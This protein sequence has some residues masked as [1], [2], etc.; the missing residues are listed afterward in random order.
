MS[1]LFKKS[2]MLL[3]FIFIIIQSAISANTDNPHGTIKWPC[4]ACHTTASWK[5]IKEALDFDHNETGFPLLGI[6]E[7]IKCR[8]CHANLT[9]AHIGIECADCHTDIH[10][11]QFGLNCQNCHTFQDWQNREGMLE[12]HI[13][14]GFPLLGV[15]AI[16][17]CDACHIVQG[18]DE[19]AGTPTECEGCH[20]GNFN[21]ADNPNHGLA[22]FDPDCRECHLPV[23]SSWRETI[24]EHPQSFLLLGAHS[25]VDCNECHSQ[26]FAGTPTTCLPCHEIDYNNADDPPHQDLGFPTDCELCHNVNRW[27]DAPFDHVQASGYELLGAHALINCNECHVGNQYDLPREC[28]GC[29]QTDYENVANPDHAVSNFPTDCT[30]CHTEIAWSPADF[31]HNL[32]NFPLTGAHQTAPCDLCHSGGQYAGM[33]TACWSCHE[34]DFRATDDPDHEVNN[35]DQDCTVCHSTSAWEPANFNHNQTN[36]PLTGA[37]VSLNCLECHASGYSSTPTDCW[38]C[39][40]GDYRGTDDPDHELNNFSQDC[41]ECH[42]TNG[43]DTDVFNHSRTD[44]PLTGAHM[45]VN[46]IQCHANGYSNIPIDCWSCHE[47]D[48]RGTD[49][50]D[51]EVNNL[52]QDCTICHTTSAWEPANFDHNQTDFPLT[53]AHIIINCIQCHANGYSN[54]PID[55]WSCHEDDYRGTDDPDHEVNNF[56]QDCTICHTTSAWEP[57]N[58]DH[59]QTDFPLTGV[60]ITLNCLE[61]HSSG[62]AGTPIDCWSCHEDDY[63]NVDDPDHIGNN[64][65]HDCTICHSTDGWDTD[66]FDHNLTGFPLTGAHA[67]QV[68]DACHSA[69]Y[70]NTPTDCFACHEDD[71]NGATNPDHPGAGF[72]TDCVTC[73]NTIDWGQTTW[74][75]D[76]QYFPIYSGSHSDEWNLCADCHVNS[77]D[78]TVFE[79]IFCHEH[80]RIDTD[81]HHEEVPDYVYES[82]ACYNCH[83]TGEH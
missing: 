83:P 65:D 20:I 35:F 33:P 71:Y 40:E 11:G 6:H 28:I 9:F 18:R 5:D 21:T 58:F 17:D 38:S 37:H 43:W 7:K 55:C 34:N 81:D 53:G 19:F 66:I 23:A 79:C 42:N 68:C 4:D 80:N 77:G 41:T 61:C 54:I 49:D 47:D 82:S 3:V 46:C 14:R 36:F 1:N 62:Y 16:A 8:Q 52:D 32:T 44:F 45:I 57:A 70:N 12:E 75:H 39:H 56:D 63:N 15:H 50:P 10:R 25:R 27:D 31:D 24:F 76:S 60:H 73:H 2:F 69:G 29:H 30:M 51:H 59:N 48:Y 78:Y 64:F 13:N 74:N 72:P 22:N 67:G 26:T